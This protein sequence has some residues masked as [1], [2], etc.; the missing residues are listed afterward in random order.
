VIRNVAAHLGLQSEGETR[1]ALAISADVA[2]S[3][4]Q[5]LIV[6]AGKTLA[7]QWFDD[8]S[9]TRFAFVNVAK[10]PVDVTYSARVEGR[11]GP[12][13][14]TALE[15]L[16]YMRPSRYCE[17]DTLS[18][19]ANAEFGGLAGEELLAAV[20]S[21]VGVNL[22]YVPGASLPT[23]GAVATMLARRG[24]C[25]D[26]AHLVVALLRACNVPARVASVYAPGLEPMDFHA[27]AEAAIDGVW[28]VVD[29]TA[30]A[31]RQSMLRIATGRD[32]SDTAFLDT[33]GAG[34]ELVTLEVQA[35]VD[36]LPKDDVTELL[37]LG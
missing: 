21:W 25:R 9:G 22:I 32:A 19:L 12:H 14:T 33:A 23:D 15:E 37:S 28:R 10:G 27:V 31:P 24:V 17:S 2:S 20:S 30:L 3:T 1:L 36:V 4:E 11:E 34:V 26:Y 35:T 18:P 29:A 7:P 13:K 6:Q 8:P 16:I 5:L